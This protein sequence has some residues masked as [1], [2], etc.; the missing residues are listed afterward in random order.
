LRYKNNQ[1]K[2][3]TKFFVGPVQFPAFFIPLRE[4]PLNLITLLNITE[5]KVIRS[6]NLRVV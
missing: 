5:N 1:S 2:D 3:I 6:N 4:V